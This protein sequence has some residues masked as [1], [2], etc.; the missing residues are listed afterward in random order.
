MKTTV[1]GHNVLLSG[2][3]GTGKSFVVDGLVKELQC[4]GLK[5]VVCSSGI[6]C[7]V[8]EMVLNL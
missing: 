5:V 8:Y 3:A 1:A 4:C 7:S 6:S 2:Q